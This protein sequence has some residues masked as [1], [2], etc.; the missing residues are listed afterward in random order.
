MSDCYICTKHTA[1]SIVPG[2]EL[3]ADDHAVVSHQPLTTPTQCAASVH[4]GHVLVEPRRHVADIGAL[5]ADEAASMQRLAALVTAAL[6]RSEG[7]ERVD[8]TTCEG[9]HLQLQLIARSPGAPR[10]DALDVIALAGRLRA[11]LPSSTPPGAA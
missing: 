1:M 4:L 6:E 10:G 2:G 11:A 5:T 9:E 3:V 7:A 8:V